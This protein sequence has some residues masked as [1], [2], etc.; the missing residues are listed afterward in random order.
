MNASIPYART[1]IAV[2]ATFALSAC[3][4]DSS[5]TID[6]AATTAA[7]QA[8]VQNIV[9]IYAENRSFD[10]LFGNFVGANGLNAVVDAGGTPT[11]AYVPQK[12][13]DGTT[14]LAT[15][16]QTWGGFTASGQTPVVTAK[17]YRASV[18]QNILNCVPGPA[19]SRR[20]SGSTYTPFNRLVSRITPPSIAEYPA[21]LWPPE[22]MTI[23]R[24]RPGINCPWHRRKMVPTSLAEAQYA[25]TAGCL[26][27]AGFASCRSW[28]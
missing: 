15:L 27:K 10:N 2:A 18:S 20:Y 12:D 9:V 13:R 5:T 19:C 28:L 16:P 25:M 24:T 21:V 7:L 11:A 8:D 22:R 14:V 26:S 23:G 17:P 3:G 1:A 4:G 6:T